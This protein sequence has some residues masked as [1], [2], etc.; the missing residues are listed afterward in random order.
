ML[1]YIVNRLLRRTRDHAQVRGD[2]HISEDLAGAAMEAMDIDRAGLDTTDRR[3]LAAIV[4]KFGSGPV[5]GAAIAAVIGEEVETVEDVYE[6][7][8]LQLGFLDRTPQGRVAT[9][10]AREH[11]PLGGQIGDRPAVLAAEALK[12][13]QA[14]LD[15]GEPSGIGL[16]AAR[17]PAKIARHVLDDDARALEALVERR[18]RRIH[19]S[20]GRELV[21]TLPNGLLGHILADADGQRIDESNLILD[22]NENDFRAKVARSL[23]RLRGQG[24][25]ATDQIRQLVLDDPDS[26]GD[27]VQEILAVYPAADD[28]EDILASDRARL[29]GALAQAGVDIDT[30]PEAVSNAFANFDRDVDLATA[31]GDLYVSADDLEANLILLD[32]A[33]GV[34]HSG[35]LDRDDFTSFYLF[36]ICV[37]SAVNDNQPDPA[38]CETVF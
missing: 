37:L 9:E 35:S 28:L 3:L 30:L 20:E 16:D 34:L 14:L 7:F 13:V 19:V 32:P 36:N 1:A 17:V 8:L 23:M 5:G 25:S 24:V 33:M 27:D 10:L 38:L 22:T 29:A 6:P 31:A 18:Q 11:L 21:F 15:L 12:Q 2:G 26:F 4:Q